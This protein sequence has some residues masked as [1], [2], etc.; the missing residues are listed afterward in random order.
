MCVIAITQKVTKEHINF[1]TFITHL[2]GKR[3]L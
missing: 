3:G 2:E 1:V